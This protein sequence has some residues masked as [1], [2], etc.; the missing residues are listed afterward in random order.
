LAVLA[1]CALGA[2]DLT[3]DWQGILKRGSRETRHLLRIAKRP[4][5]GWAAKLF[6]IDD[7][8][9]WGLGIPAGALRVSGSTLQFAVEPM[10]A[11]YRG[12]I[13]G[14]RIAGTWT[15][16]ASQPFELKRA[17]GEDA[18]RDPS[19]HRVEFL[20]VADQVRVE[21]LEWGGP[22]RPLVLL[23]GQGNTAH[24]FD[25]LA[26]KLNGAFHVFGITR[27][28]FGASSRPPTPCDADCL[29]G[30][31]AAAI[32]GLKLERPM[33]AGHSI[34][35]QELTSMGA[36][37]AE[38]VSGLI[39]LE[40]GYGYALPVTAV[41]AGE[42]KYAD[43]PLPILAIFAVPHA[44]PERIGSNPAA[45]AAFEARDAVAAG[46]QAQRFQA[47]HPGARVVRLPHA[48]HYVFLSNEAEVV[49][50]ITAFARG[51]SE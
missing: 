48:D 10:H 25:E 31:V 40:A 7:T 22:G 30:D 2:Q 26:S 41:V 43:I 4:G 13:R 46:E 42:Q 21:V 47:A 19:P 17:T 39:Y 32:D 16:G 44:A 12:I 18:W 49:R 24:V 37:H 11:T 45:I 9:D 1:A 35:G 33:L 3:G 38:K 51:V 29:A 6:N 36:R 14:D 50:E 27:R 34:A 5:G 28:G 23:A 20:N 8:H 15:Q